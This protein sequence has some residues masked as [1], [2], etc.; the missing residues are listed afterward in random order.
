M[1]ED[2]SIGMTRNS[3]EE[4]IQACSQQSQRNSS[5]SAETGAAWFYQRTHATVQHARFPAVNPSKRA[6]VARGVGR[7]K[8]WTCAK[9]DTSCSRTW[10]KPD[11]YKRTTYTTVTT[12]D[13]QLIA[14]PWLKLF[15]LSKVRSS[16]HISHHTC[17]SWK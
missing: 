12:T 15:V 17:S 8:P 7:F 1:P 2:F 3:D 14:S 5:K 6:H 4:S 13:H 16:A 9:Q 10:G 11:I